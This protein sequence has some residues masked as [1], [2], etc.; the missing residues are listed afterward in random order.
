MA[1]TVFFK[2]DGR[3]VH[4]ILAIKTNHKGGPKLKTRGFFSVIRIWD[5]FPFLVVLYFILF[6]NSVW[7]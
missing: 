2:D 3:N 1:I 5:S 6:F 7:Q 4:P